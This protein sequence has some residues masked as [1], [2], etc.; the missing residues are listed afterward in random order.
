M[1]LLNLGMIHSIRQSL[2]FR[3]GAI[4]ELPVL[5]IHELPLLNFG[6]QSYSKSATP[7]LFCRDTTM[8]CPNFVQLKQSPAPDTAVPRPYR[9]GVQSNF[10]GTQHC[11]VLIYKN[12]GVQILGNY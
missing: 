3:V 12:Y 8:L 9:Y 6:G 7:N 5:A 10:V 2:K 11:C 1:A 4:H